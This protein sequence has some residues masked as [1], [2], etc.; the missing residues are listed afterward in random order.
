M[1]INN[2]GG[3]KITLKHNVHNNNFGGQSQS[4]F[5]TILKKISKYY[6]FNISHQKHGSQWQVNQCIT[7]L[8]KMLNLIICFWGWIKMFKLSKNM[9]NELLDIQELLFLT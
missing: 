7:T 5:M 8:K 3:T 9:G 4:K 2:L 6:A 1:D